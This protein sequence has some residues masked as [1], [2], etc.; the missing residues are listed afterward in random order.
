MAELFFEEGKDANIFLQN[1]TKIL[2]LDTK[3][4]DIP[5]IESSFY[6]SNP[7][8]VTMRQVNAYTV[9][10]TALLEGEVT[11]YALV[12]TSG[13]TYLAKYSL[14]ILSSVPS[15]AIQM[16]KT[17]TENTT[18]SF[19]IYDLLRISLN[20]FDFELSSEA[21]FTWLLDGIVLSKVKNSQGTDIDYE[22]S[23]SIYQTFTEGTHEIQLQFSDKSGTL[24]DTISRTFQIGKEVNQDRTLSFEKGNQLNLLVNGEII[25]ISA[26]LDGGFDYNITYTW[27]IENQSIL[28]FVA[29]TS[30]PTVVLMPVAEGTT[31][32]T[33][34]ATIGSE[35]NPKIISQTMQ[36]QIDKINTMEVKATESVF[37]PKETGDFVVLINGK[38]Y[39]NVTLNIAVTNTETGEKVSFEQ[40]KN[41]ITIKD[42]QKGKYQLTT[43]YQDLSEDYS[44]Q[45]T[46]FSIQRFLKDIFPYL[47][48]ALLV[49]LIF[50]IIL[51]TRKA[52][53]EI[54]LNRLKKRLP[55]FDRFATASQ[56]QKVSLCH[57]LKKS[58]RGIQGLLDHAY[59]D[60]EEELKGCIEKTNRLLLL[61]TIILSENT[62]DHTNFD[63]IKT[64]YYQVLIQELDEVVSSRK[65]YQK[66][67]GE[68][69]KKDVETLNKKKKASKSDK[70]IKVYQELIK[71]VT[72]SR[73]EDDD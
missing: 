10:V 47:L 39:D 22:N 61:F 51:G 55:L 28:Q 12:Y 65:A 69:K 1:P 31:K 21:E 66:N 41:H 50:W 8:L 63:K 3:G 49:V 36:I 25:K 52:N 54:A 17:N 57:K 53:D 24:T 13:K 60:G 46:S 14:S 44:F 68:N 29:I 15:F 56:K 42:Q 19:T 7:D 27:N 2:H 33:V 18:S 6:C 71:S 70:E 58:L 26:L 23:S 32:L 48:F 34:Y 72:T 11:I 35:H 20:T 64:S 62:I 37:L 59:D 67:I 45:V 4:L 9:E 5:Q 16:E 43:S 30:S 40:D 38:T 73:E